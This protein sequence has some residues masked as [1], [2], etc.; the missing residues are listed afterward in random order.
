M[1]YV[2]A[3]C[4]GPDSISVIEDVGGLSTTTITAHEIAHRFLY[5]YFIKKNYFQSWG[6]S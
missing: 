5:N 4:R 1:T 2:K 6:I 3:M